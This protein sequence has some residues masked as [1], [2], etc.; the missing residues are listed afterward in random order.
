METFMSRIQVFTN[1]ISLH[2]DFLRHLDVVIHADFIYAVWFQSCQINKNHFRSS[3]LLDIIMWSVLIHSGAPGPSVFID[4]DTVA[5]ILLSD[6]HQWSKQ[7]F[8]FFLL[9][10]IYRVIIFIISFVLG[11]QP[12]FLPERDRLSKQ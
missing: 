1:L 10:L 3:K 5:V 2:W 9:G 4:S 7:L 6:Q 12:S 11:F 8:F